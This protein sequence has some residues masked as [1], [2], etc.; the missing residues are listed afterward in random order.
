MMWYSVNLLAIVAVLLLTQQGHQVF[1]Q[2][3]DIFA[4]AKQALASS[5]ASLQTSTW[6]IDHGD[7]SRSKY[8]FNAGLPGDVR[9]EDIKIVSNNQLLGAQWLY[10][11]G[12]KS[13]FIYLIRGDAMKGYTAG[14]LDSTTLEVLQEY[15]LEKAVYTGGMLIHRNGHVYCIHSNKLY[16]FYNGDLSNTTMRVLPTKLNSGL[17]CTNGMLVTKDGYLVVKQWAL[18]IGDI[19]LF[20]LGKSEIFKAFF[21]ILLIS[22]TTML[23]MVRHKKTKAFQPVKAVL[24]GVVVGCV[25]FGSILCL[26]WFKMLGSYNPIRYFAEGFFSP[27]SG[28]GE[29]KLIDPITLEVKAAATL[30]ERCSFARMAISTVTNSEG[31]EEDAIVLLGD[32]AVHQYRWRPSSS[33][34]FWIPAWSKE[35]RRAGDGSFPGTGPAIF[36]DTT[37]FTDNTFPVFLGKKTYSMFSMS[38]SKVPHETKAN[39]V[40]DIQTNVHY[41]AADKISIPQSDDAT[42]FLA[43]RH[44]FPK[45]PAVPVADPAAS[46]QGGFMFWSISIFPQIA[47]KSEGH[48]IVWDSARYLVQA[49]S[50]ENIT[51]IHWELK[52]VRNSDCI[53]NVVDR[54]HVYVNDYSEAPTETNDWMG[55]VT[56]SISHFR[57]STKYFLVIDAATG[58]EIVRKALPEG[59]NGVNPSLLVPGANNDVFIGTTKGIVRLYV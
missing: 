43:K 46:K 28:G 49:R 18:H 42:H 20:G 52:N 14:K 8:V 7:V 9:A 29:L 15:P 21:A 32:E 41:L 48:A 53:T 57:Q 23:F 11:G 1:G 50:L 34:L 3:E 30:P 45:A 25:L 58:K 44:N 38:M 10:T 40:V 33:E 47:D 16:M 24:L 17:V 59:G 6:P 19:F 55:A 39:E 13:E 4:F 36:N 22:I 54:Q 12:S 26:I 5:R 37:Y 35:Y 51:N 27:Y 2:D 56:G 31:V